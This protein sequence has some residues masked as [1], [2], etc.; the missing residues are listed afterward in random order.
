M[1]ATLYNCSNLLWW[2]AA[3]TSSEGVLKGAAPSGVNTYPRQ[4]KQ[5]AEAVAQHGAMMSTPASHH[6]SLME[7]ET[8]PAALISS[9]LQSLLFV[10]SEGVCVCVCVLEHASLAFLFV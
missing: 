10:P 5:R 4:P 9:A 7:S 1:H 2:R 6:R 8:D 3:H